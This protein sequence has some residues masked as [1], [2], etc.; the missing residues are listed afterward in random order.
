[1]DTGSVETHRLRGANRRCGVREENGSV[2]VGI[3]V[4]EIHLDGNRFVGKRDAAFPVSGEIAL[5]ANESREEKNRDETRYTH[6]PAYNL[7]R[8]IL[9][10]HAGLT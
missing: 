8:R 7:K 6:Y 4:I 1:M 2:P 10:P 5:R 3:R 9:A